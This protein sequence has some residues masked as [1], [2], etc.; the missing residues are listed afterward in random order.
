MP[1]TIRRY[2]VPALAVA[3]GGAMFAAAAVAGR[4]WFG[5]SLFGIMLAYALML[6]FSRDSEPVAM[7]AEESADERRR[8]IQLKAGY[9]SLNVVALVVV[10]G[11]I[12][13]ILRGGDGGPWALIGAVGGASF[14]AALFVLSRR[15]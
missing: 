1:T 14:V 7:L 8:L 3:L 5:V 6:M 11:F 2:A 13:D 10:A 4:L 9:F 12:I 15:H